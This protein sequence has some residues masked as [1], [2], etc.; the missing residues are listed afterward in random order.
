E[1]TGLSGTYETQVQQVSVTLSNSNWEL[2]G[3][4]HVQD[5]AI[6]PSWEWYVGTDDQ[7]ASQWVHT[8]ETFRH[9]A[10]IAFHFRDAEPMGGREPKITSI[11]DGLHVPVWNGSEWVMEYSRNPA[12]CVLDFL[13]NPRYGMGVPDSRIDFDSFITAAEYCD[14]E[15]E[16]PDGVMEPRFRLDYVIDAERSSLD[17]LEDMLATFRAFIPY[18][19]GKL[20]LRI[21]RYETPVYSFTNDNIVE[22]SFSY[23]VA[24]LR[25]I[26]NQIR[27]EWINPEANF[28]RS[29]VV[30][31]NEAD[32]IRRGE[33]VSR[34]IPLLGI[35]RA[36]QAGRMARFLHDSAYRANTFCE[37]R[38]GI[39]A[40]HVEVGDVVLV[41]H[42]VPGWVN[43]QFRVLEIEEM[44]NDEAR[45]RLREYVPQ[46]A[47]TAAACIG[48]EVGGTQ[49]SPGRR[50]GNAGDSCDV[51]RA[52]GRV[53]CRGRCLLAQRRGRVVATGSALRS[54][55]LRHPAHGACVV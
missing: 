34:T 33:V 32:Q 26:P 29:G 13:R 48:T 44:E 37:F 53:L 36:S 43:K 17:T 45:L 49:A 14:E 8:G 55:E 42:D 52:C 5:V 7:Q 4:T 51:E 21:E 35:T 28:E 27:V 46:S 20:R 3:D 18:S 10:Y 1:L 38:V 47:C 9:T 39:D 15:V 30:Y 41:S 54:T 31:D 6:A 16:G 12:W 2:W 22:D 11:V 19:D 40:L 50:L 25:S 24:P 23:S